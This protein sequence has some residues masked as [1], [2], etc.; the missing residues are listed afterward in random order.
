MVIAGSCVRMVAPFAPLELLAAVL[1]LC[2]AAA[3]GAR[4]PP[5]SAASSAVSLLSCC[6][7]AREPLSLRGGGSG[8]GVGIEAGLC[9]HVHELVCAGHA[10]RGELGASSAHAGRAAR[11]RCAV[12]HSRQ[13]VAPAAVAHG[14]LVVRH[15]VAPCVAA[16]QQPVLL[17]LH[18]HEG[19][20]QHLHTSGDSCLNNLEQT[21]A[22]RWRR[23]APPQ[24]AGKGAVARLQAAHGR[25]AAAQAHLARDVAPEALDAWDELRPPARVGRWAV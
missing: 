5:A 13:G 22:A 6:A 2:W 8:G 16:P 20:A 10:A 25:S 24:Q 23:L 14:E 19:L 9:A 11:A 18:Q 4:G 12:G 15:G 3:A 7:A 1:V 17:A 21:P